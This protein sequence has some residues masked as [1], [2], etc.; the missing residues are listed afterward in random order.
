[1]IKYFLKNVRYF[2][3]ES[4]SVQEAKVSE[5]V[6]L[7]HCQKPRVLRGSLRRIR[8]GIH[9]ESGHR[10]TPQAAYRAFK[11]VVTELGM[12]LV[13]FHD[14]RHSYAVASLRSGD[15]V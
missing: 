14:L 4:D 11:L 15:D 5:R 7:P 3:L 6:Y 8:S 2:L 9:D 10:I 1:M 12:P 13:R